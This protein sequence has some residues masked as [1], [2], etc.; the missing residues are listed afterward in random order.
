M[1][2]IVLGAGAIGSYV[3]ARLAAAGQAVVM[4]ARP[5]HVQAWQRD[6]LSVS[7][8][9]G[10]N[11]HL[12][13]AQLHLAPDLAAAW[14]AAQAIKAGP[15]ATG[16]C[17]VLLCVKGGATAS[18][19]REIAAVCPAGTAIVSLQNGVDN[20]ARIAAGA[21]A[22]HP[23]AGMVPYNVILKNANA[24]H[25]ASAGS[26]FLARDAVT[27]ELAPIMEAAGLDV[28]LSDDMPSVQWGK[29]LLNL[30]NPINA[31]S[32]MPLK[33]QLLDRDFRWVL[34]ALQSEALA[35]MARAGVQ[36]AQIA[37]V[38]PRVLPH[39]L[40]LPDWLF[41]RLASRMLRM[42]ASARS[43]MWDDVQ[44]GRTTEID[45]LCGA[46]VRLAA[47]QGTS[48]PQNAAICD[49]VA[50][51]AKGRRWTGAELRRHLG[52]LSS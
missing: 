23:L 21:P 32:D 15:H 50:G 42:D 9:E 25:R 30:N 16:P 43:S 20:V 1:K 4:V 34:A 37:A 19:A 44:Q 24:V 40:R 29:L 18:A 35:A 26:I 28:T 33:A 13:P 14:A 38:S 12:T 41:R 3:G 51:H 27:S 52:T 6:G 5:R 49:L 2:F 7:D 47:G 8:L 22:M 46:V 31:L 11:A 39:V 48:A 36:P 17:V 10:F 45:D